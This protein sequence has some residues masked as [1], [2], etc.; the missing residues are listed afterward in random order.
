MQRVLQAQSGLPL[1]RRFPLAG[2]HPCHHGMR[3]VKD[4]DAVKAAAEPVDDLLDFGW[5][6]HLSPACAGLWCVS[7]WKIDPGMGVIG[8]QF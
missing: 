8:V 4:D 3:F 2:A 5:L 6:C 1:L 7:A